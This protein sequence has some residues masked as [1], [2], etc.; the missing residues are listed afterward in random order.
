MTALVTSDDVMAPGNER[1]LEGIAFGCRCD[2]MAG[3]GPLNRSV[4]L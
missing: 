2:W 3:H 1:P 4:G